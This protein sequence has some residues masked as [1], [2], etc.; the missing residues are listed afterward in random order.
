MRIAILGTGGV[1]GYFGG[2]LARAGNDVHFIARG[3]HLQAIR[4]HGLRVE[5]VHGDFVISP[6][7]ATDDPRTIGPV[8]LVIVA[9]K[10]YQIEEAIQASRPLLGPRTVVL[11]L[12]NGV[13]ATELLAAAL[14][15]DPVLGGICYVGSAAVAPGIIRQISPF[16]R[17]VLGEP[18]GPIS[19]RV[20]AIA[21]QLSQARLVFEPVDDIQ[22]ARWT[23]FAF[24]APFSG[25][26]AATRVPAGEIVACRETRHLLE[27]AIQEVETVARTGG[28]ALAPDVVPAT[29]ALCDRLPAEQLASMQRDL[30]AGRPSELESLVGFVVGR[31]AAL[32]VSTPTFAYLYATLLPQERRARARR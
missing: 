31:G 8:D 25:V 12:L 28:I 27:S 11:P 23:K 22:A 13:D 5:S 6:A 17:I 4:E 18:H 19:P 24:I 9:V 30:L 14:G 7:N 26:G 1:G 32:A 15:A 10:G 3:A 29:L 21:D 16:S 2:L 20:R